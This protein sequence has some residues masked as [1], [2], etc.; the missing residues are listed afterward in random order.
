MIIP[1]LPSIGENISNHVAS[2]LV[3]TIKFWNE[4]LFENILPDTYITLAD[5]NI[6]RKGNYFVKGVFKKD[7]VLYNENHKSTI[8]LDYTHTEETIEANLKELISTLVHEM[9]HQW[10]SIHNPNKQVKNGHGITW[11]KKMEELGLPPVCI[12]TSWYNGAITH[13]IEESGLFSQVYES[14]PEKLRLAYPEFSKYIVFPGRRKRK[15]QQT[16]FSYKCPSCGKIQKL[17]GEDNT[18]S[19]AGSLSNQ[20]KHI[21]FNHNGGI[22]TI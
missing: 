12:G 6:G 13:R 16:W 3:D 20:H 4:N 15:Y 11:R 22:I 14:F 1:Q 10:D 9:V 5:L 2:T 7:E 8:I 17:Q 21:I 19:C 18:A